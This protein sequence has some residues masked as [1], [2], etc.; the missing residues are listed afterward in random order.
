MA[1][2]IQLSVKK[3]T[4]AVFS[5]LYGPTVSLCLVNINKQKGG[6][7][8]GLFAIANATTIA[9]RLDPVEITF[10]QSNLCGHLVNFLENGKLTRFPIV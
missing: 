5:N 2:S 4:K 9:L 7:D 3:L 1:Q 8:W 6:A 10:Q